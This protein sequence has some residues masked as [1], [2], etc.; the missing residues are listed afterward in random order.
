MDPLQKVSYS[1]IRSWCLSCSFL[2]DKTQP[3]LPCHQNQIQQVFVGIV[4][5]KHINKHKC[6]YSFL[7]VFSFYHCEKY[8]HVEYG[9]IL[10]FAFPLRKS[11]LPLHV[12]IVL[13]SIPLYVHL[14]LSSFSLNQFSD[15]LLFEVRFLEVSDLRGTGGGLAPSD[16]GDSPTGSCGDCRDNLGRTACGEL[17]AVLVVVT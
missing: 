14:A 17:D 16:V 9:K 11:S 1:S 10:S 15:W 3:F 4:T 2:L 8:H 6:L 12:N 7:F 5:G 13:S